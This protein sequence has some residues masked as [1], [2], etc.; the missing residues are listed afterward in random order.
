MLRSRGCRRSVLPL[1]KS[2]MER[3][4]DV[5]KV[6]LEEL[7]ATYVAEHPWQFLKVVARCGEEL[8]HEA[9]SVKGSDPSSLQSTVTCWRRLRM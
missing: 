5:I 6:G 1:L 9:C 3:G 8:E 7:H 4:V 2:N